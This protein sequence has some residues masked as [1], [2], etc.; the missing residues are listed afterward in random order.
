MALKYGIAGQNAK[1][2]QLFVA[3]GA[4]P[5]LRFYDG[6]APANCATAPA[7]SQVAALP[8]PATPMAAAAAGS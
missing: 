3:I 2:D 1:L 5:K 6:T 8:L 7:G 4:S